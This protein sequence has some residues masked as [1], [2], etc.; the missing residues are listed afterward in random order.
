[1]KRGIV[2]GLSIL[3][4]FLIT[5]LTVIKITSDDEGPEIRTPNEQII[6]TAGTGEQSLL[7]G[8]SAIDAKDGDVSDSLRVANVLPAE[9][10]VTA[11]II[12]MAKDKKNN[13]TK[14]TSTVQYQTGT[15][16]QPAGHTD[17]QDS[18]VNTVTP[19]TDTQPGQ[20]GNTSQTDTPQFETGTDNATLPVESNEGSGVGEAE[21]N[22]AIAELSE[23][24]PRFHLKEYAVTIEAG[25]EFDQ[26]SYVENI[27]DDNDTREELYRR[28]QISGN[29]DVNTPGVYELIYH[30]ADSDGNSSNQAKLVITVE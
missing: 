17:V 1:M 11:S 3:T 29:V 25:S 4:V 24:S 23:E 12:Y 7:R 30:V 2:A 8:V 19:E 6:Y 5:V 16:M 28:I 9:D 20:E 13:V 26:L 15:E 27:E 18:D 22:A 14:I 21:N 10:G